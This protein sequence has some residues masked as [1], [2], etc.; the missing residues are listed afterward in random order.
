M[1]EGTTLLALFQDIDPAAHAIE[2]LREMGLDDNQMNVISGIPFREEILGRPTV[3]THVPRIALAGAIAGFAVAVFLIWGVPL[4]YPLYVGG[5]PMF[6]IPPLLVVGFEMIM[7]GMLVSAFLGVFFDSSFPSYEPAL[8]APE[9]SDGKIAL[10]FD[11]P[12]DKQAK[13][14]DAMK[15]LGAELVRTVEAQVL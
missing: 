10:F 13:F 15:S 14:K 11:C 1:S 5:Q 2:K 6:P 3:R 9:V 7:L 12:T 8:Y 4:L